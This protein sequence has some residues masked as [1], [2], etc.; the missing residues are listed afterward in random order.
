MGALLD[1][2]TSSLLGRETPHISQTLFGDDDVEVMLRLVNVSA[3]RHNA[4]NTSRV[5]LGR[6]SGWR[7]HDGILGRTEEIGRSSKTV[8][9]SAAHN[10]RRVGVRVNV[11]FYRSVHTN[12]A[13]TS[14]NLGAVG[15]LL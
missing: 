6:S 13:Q 4:R 10:A 12:H 9:H 8:E 2:D 7:M 15:H 11:N 3:H 1:D 5:R 14:D